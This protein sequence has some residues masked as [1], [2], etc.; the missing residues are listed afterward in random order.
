VSWPCPLSFPHRGLESAWAAAYRAIALAEMALDAGYFAAGCRYLAGSGTDV[1]GTMPGISLHH[2]LEAL[3]QL[4]HSP[5]QALAAATSNPAEVFGWDEIGAIA[6][7]NRAGLVVLGSDPRVDVRNLRDV[8]QTVRAGVVLEREDLLVLRP[9]ADG[10]L[11]R[12]EPMAIPE[13]LLTAEGSPRAE[14][15]HLNE[16][17][18]DEITYVSDGLRIEGHII[19][20]RGRGSHQTGPQQMGPH[21]CLIYNRG[22]N[23][24][25]GANS[26]LRVARRLAKFA[27]WGYVVVASQYRGNAGG[28][29]QEEFGGADVA[30]VLNLIPLLESL[31]GEA[32]ATRIGGQVGTDSNNCFYPTSGAAYF[33]NGFLLPVVAS[34]VVSRT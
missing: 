11:L 23:R 16:V 32:D 6:P 18:I 12:R 34:T 19:T 26:P 1:W 13:E 31:P 25:F 29:G 7:G 10:Q 5:R 9:L 3:V 17:D 33:R 30:D 15:I 28:E 2:E 27:S 8:R 14:D 21:P 4:G 24:D 20:P 22:G